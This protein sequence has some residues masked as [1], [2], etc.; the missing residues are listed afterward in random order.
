[1]TIG[2]KRGPVSLRERGDFLIG[3]DGLR[4]I[5]RERLGLGGRDEALFSGRVA[6]RAQVESTL[7]PEHLRR[8]EVTLRL[9]AKAHLVHYPLRNSA[10]VNMVAV[11]E[12]GWRAQGRRSLGQ[13]SRRPR[14]SGARFRQLGARTP[15]V[16]RRRRGWRAWPLY[17]REPIARFASEHVALLGDSAHPDG[18]SS[19]R[20]GGSGDRGRW[21]ARRLPQSIARPT[22]GACRLFPPPRAPRSAESKQRPKR[23]RGSMPLRPARLGARSACARS[24]G[25]SGC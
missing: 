12:S 2:V 9:G 25:Q 4:S 15:R 16:D 1:M 3:A 11:I 23:R 14:R 17:D 22:G 5:V 24:A 18:S 6:F 19:R 7:A 10:I 21:R 8:P 20:E 13:R